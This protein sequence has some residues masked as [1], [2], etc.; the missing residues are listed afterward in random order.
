MG[1]T[2]KQTKRRNDESTLTPSKAQK[3]SFWGERILCVKK[4]RHIAHCGR[5]TGADLSVLLT[6]IRFVDAADIRVI[7]A[8]NFGDMLFG[9]FWC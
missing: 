6:E 8:D 9:L 3:R 4:A 7:M 2:D 1:W 5:L